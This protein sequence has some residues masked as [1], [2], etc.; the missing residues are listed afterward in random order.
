M[1]KARPKPMLVHKV[2]SPEL[3]AYEVAAHIVDANPSIETLGLVAYHEGPSWRDLAEPQKQ[4]NLPLLLRGIQQDLAKRTLITV[5][6]KEL[7]VAKLQGIARNL[8]KDQ[9]LGMISRVSLAGGQTGHIPMMDFTC[10]P[11]SENLGV[12]IRLLGEIQRGKGFLVESGHSYHYYGVELLDEE[13][14]RIFLGKCLLM[15]G[16]VDDRYVGHQ[17]VDG[18]CVLRLS[19][20]KRKSQLP[21]VVAQV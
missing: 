17:L 21:R 8:R 5:A 18:H 2:P 13:G 3:T 1:N 10:K 12:L 15:P 11:S 4:L 7:S 14:W 9:L 20:G 6:R 19:M 16:Y